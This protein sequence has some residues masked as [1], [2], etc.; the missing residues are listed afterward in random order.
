VDERLAA[1]A[2][3]A[4]ARAVPEGVVL[5]RGE[6][7]DGN[8]V[9]VVA[10]PG[11]GHAVAGALRDQRL[12]P[13]PQEPGRV[14]WRRLP[15]ETV[16]VDVL[17]PHAWPARYPALDDVL[18]R[19][20]NGTLGL[21]VA[22]AGDRLLI[23]AAEAV[24]G[25]P[26]AKT[27]RRLHAAWA[28]PGA[29]DSLAAAARAEPGLGGLARLAQV[30]ATATAGAGGRAD[31]LPLPVALRA[32][33]RSAQGRAA[34]GE[35]LA[36]AAGMT[37]RPPL[38]R[39]AGPPADAVA[40]ARLVALSGMDGAGKSTAGL[41]LLEALE[42]AGQP[43][44]VDRIRLADELGLLGVTARLVRRILGRETSLVDPEAPAPAA[45]AA[46][47]SGR[48]GVVDA[49]WV[50]AVAGVAVRNARRT[51]RIRRRGLSVVCDRWLADAL[52][53]LRIRYGPHPAA[54][55]LLRRGFPRADVAVL[56]EV[57]GAT[58]ARR[59]PGDQTE[60]VLHAM[61]ERYAEVGDRL[62]LPRVDASAPPGEVATR[63]RALALRA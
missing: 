18:G 38:P 21:P 4:L 2:L 3:D 39:V 14:M 49:V 60:A 7:L 47:G 57:D 36:T 17:A 32:A 40:Q 26:L 31:A 27:R 33:A 48:D 28:E 20:R 51:G 52:V 24:A 34:L 53:D 22:S 5:W 6:G 55:W 25:W 62:G 15:G 63:L 58:A 1:E 59:K 50:L 35:R 61:S 56:L 30:L 54:E 8:D 44:V 29:G 43:A 23:H 37:V 9:D 12:T 11:R 16:V 13:A 42:A 46:G 10:V 41:D 19:A 45:P